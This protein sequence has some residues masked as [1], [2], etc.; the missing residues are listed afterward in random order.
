MENISPKTQIGQALALSR[1][2]VAPW[3]G[4]GW[5]LARIRL[6]A[7]VGHKQPVAVHKESLM[8]GSMRWA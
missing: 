4:V 7:C 6:S 5:M 3:H 8:I 1:T 2:G